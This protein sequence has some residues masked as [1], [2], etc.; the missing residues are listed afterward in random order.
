MRTVQLDFADP[1]FPASLVEVDPPALPADDWAR[2]EITC[3]GV[4]GSDLHLFKPT[5]GPTPILGSYVALPMQLGH[6]IAGRVL[7]TGPACAV[8]EGTLVAVDPVIGC[9]ARGIV[10]LCAKCA[11]GAASAC[12]HFGSGVR[13]PGMGLGFTQGLG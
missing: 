5:T 2:V 4:C 13:T 7:E 1:S 9:A 3:G 11:S 12:A 8:P 10:P 6:E